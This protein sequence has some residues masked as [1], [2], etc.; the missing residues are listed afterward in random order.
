M[1]LSAGNEQD[2]NRIALQ[3]AEAVLLIVDPKAQHIAV[4]S[5]GSRHVIERQLGQR[6]AQPVR[7][8]SAPAWGDL[9]LMEGLPKPEHIPVRITDFKHPHLDPVDLLNFA[10]S[11]SASTDGGALGGNVVGLKE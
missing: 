9:F 11:A 5:N 8:R 10:R 3:H 4:V 7:L 6:L 1:L 2:G